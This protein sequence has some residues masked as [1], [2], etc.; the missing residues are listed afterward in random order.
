MLRQFAAKVR[1]VELAVDPRF[2]EMF[3]ASMQFA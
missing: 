2:Q 3:V 1:H